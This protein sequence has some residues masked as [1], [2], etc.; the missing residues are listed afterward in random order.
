MH[1]HPTLA[2]Y[3]TVPTIHV[4]THLSPSYPWYP[5][6]QLSSRV[7]TRIGSFS[8]SSSATSSVPRRYASDHHGPQD[9]WPQTQDE[10]RYEPSHTYHHTIPPP[11][12]S[13][14]HLHPAAPHSRPPLS[15]TDCRT[16]RLSC[17]FRLLAVCVCVR[18]LWGYGA[19]TL[20]VFLYAAYSI[21]GPSQKK[22]TTTTTT[23]QTTK[24]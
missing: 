16:D 4:P 2:H 14:P 7:A 13:H 11:P 3:P 1:N 17:S 21:R 20:G 22:T 10:L 18:R 19:A 6:S 24:H 9:N 23:T 8:S 15:L 5:F 12:P